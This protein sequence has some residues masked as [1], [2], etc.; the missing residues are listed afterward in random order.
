MKKNE[1]ERHGHKMNFSHDKN[2]VVTALYTEHLQENIDTF[3]VLFDKCSDVIKRKFTIGGENKIDIYIAYIDNMVNRDSVEEDMIKYLV[4]KMDDMPDENQFD[5]IKAKG[6]RTADLSEVITMEDVV[7]GVLSGDTILMVDG[8]KKAIKIASKGYPGRGVSENDSE[9]SVRGAKDSFVESIAINKV[10]IRRRIRDTKLK[11][12]QMKIGVRSRTDVA[13][14]YISDIAKEDLIEDIKNKLND[15]VID[16]ILDSSMLEQLTESTWYSPFPQ[17]QSTVRPD[18]TASAIL[19]GRV[20]IV[21]D[22]SPYVLLIPTTAN[23]FFQASDDYYSKWEVA[24]FTRILRYLGAILA[25]TLPGLYIAITN[26]Q[27]EMI[28]TSL[29]LSFAA[30]RQGVPFSVVFEVI[31]MEL[32]FELLR[33]AGIRLPG[34]MGNTIGIVGGLIIGDAAVS[35]NLVSPIIVIVVALTAISSFAIPN[36][37]FASA[38]RLTRYLIIFLSAWLGLYGFILG[39]IM[40]FTHL[41]SLESFGIPYLMPFDASGMEGEEEAADALVRFPIFKLR[42]RPIYA[43]EDEKIRLRKK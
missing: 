11:V 16:G 27:P 41:C 7:Q 9:V 14:I 10:L 5:Y 20:A 6:L 39:V 35:A 30:A 15:F 3:E 40:V 28:P 12:E 43:K 37:A 4:Y 26:F 33:E 2:N 1:W 34:P 21:V 32:A 19:E 18:K 36:E 22:N 25:M 24:T 29:A 38:F 23:S 17:F 8:Y 31:I 13:I 42:K